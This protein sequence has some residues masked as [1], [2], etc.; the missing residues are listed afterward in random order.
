MEHL[1]EYITCLIED[2]TL[3]DALKHEP[4]DTLNQARLSKEEKQAMWS[5]DPECVQAMIGARQI[6]A[7]VREAIIKL[8]E[9]KRK[10][11]A[12][13]AARG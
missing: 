10:V 12:A 1:G 8:G 13:R 7:S 5:G 11:D 4:A 9:Y 2:P 3:L 6:P